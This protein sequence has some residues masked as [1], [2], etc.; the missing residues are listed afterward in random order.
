MLE[1][2]GVEVSDALLK[3]WQERVQLA[4]AHLG[5]PDSRD[6]R[7]DAT[8]SARATA[9]AR[10][11]A[12]R[13][14]A[15]GASLAIAA[16]CDQLL[17]AAEVNEWALCSSLLQLDAARWPAL[18]QALIDAANAAAAPGEAEPGAGATAAAP[19]L[20]ELFA[21]FPPRLE[22]QAALARFR[23]L[24]SLEARPRLPALIDAAEARGVLHVLD[25][26]QLTFGSGC[27]GQSW[28]LDSLPDV[29]EVPWERIHAV[30]A[31]LI[32]GSNGK[33]TIV[34][35]LAS[36]ARA[37]GLVDGYNCTDG[38]FVGGTQLQSGDFSGPVGTRTVL[39]DRRVEMAIL[40]TARGG[41]LRRGLA[42]GRAR[43]A[44]VTN[45][46]ADHF[47][48][49][50][51]HD[52]AGLADVKLVVASA[53]PRD[54]LLVLNADDPLLLERS[55]D[56]DVPI[57]WFA[58]DHDHEVLRE[59]RR[60]NGWTSGVRAGRLVVTRGATGVAAEAFDLGEVAAMPL[61]VAGSADYNIANLAAAAL[62]A[63]ALDLAPS[64]I[65]TVLA[66]FGAE[67]TDNLGRLMRYP[68]RGAEV[69]LDYAHN[70]AGLG[71]LMKVARRLL[72]SRG[73][74]LALLI[75]QAGNREN[76]DIEWLAETAVSF[77][78]DFVVIKED[79]KF[80][81]GRAAGEVPAL[82]RAALLRAGQPEAS[83][84]VQPTEMQAVRRLLD[85]ARADDVVVLPVHGREARTEVVSLLSA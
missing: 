82:L 18:E 43:V 14:H 10:V 5:W 47:G 25:E 20:I 23:Q 85:W 48:E 4:R 37:Q 11:I 66:R 61:T 63:L 41:I 7:G 50:G 36:C 16:P 83:L 34:R 70:P 78:P 35:L 3:S 26:D 44:V 29:A 73:G 49:Y 9:R 28:A 62:A 2:V 60:R 32:T 33:T 45:I 59:H 57:G 79:E 27:A 1:V 19:T 13:R 67:P 30:P 69:L 74:R 38:V 21:K 56:L 64:T 76:K 53:V 24:A 42:A 31:A 22:R 77:R 15:G 65:A 39:R 58:L 80:L 6:I 55:K 40:E 8:R 54:G 68:Y 17:T 46:S 71:G 72:G 81:R 52:L 75:G 51:I 84:D 12:V